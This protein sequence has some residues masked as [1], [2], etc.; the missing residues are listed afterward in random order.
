MKKTIITIDLNKLDKNRINTKTYTNKKGEEITVKENK[1]EKSAATK[2][3]KKKKKQKIKKEKKETNFLGSG[4]QF[5]QLEDMDLSQNKEEEEPVI[6][7]DVEEIDVEEDLP[8]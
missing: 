5:S 7:E 3:K 1:K 2:K 4:V 8:F 6:Q